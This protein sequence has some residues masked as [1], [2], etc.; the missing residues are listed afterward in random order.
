M[1]RLEVKSSEGIDRALLFY[2]S[3]ERGVT[4]K[5]DGWMLSRTEV[6]V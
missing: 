5:L 1:D 4:V 3:G 6:Q 2:F